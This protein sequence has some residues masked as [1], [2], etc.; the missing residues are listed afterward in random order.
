MGAMALPTA[1]LMIGVPQTR[2]FTSKP[3]DTMYSSTAARPLSIATKKASMRSSSSSG[4][5]SGGSM[6][7]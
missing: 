3:R 6:P 7:P 2:L 5:G 1:M 4:S